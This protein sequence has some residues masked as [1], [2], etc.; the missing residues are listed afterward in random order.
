MDTKS[1]RKSYTAEF[2]RQAVAM[3]VAENLPVAE[4]ARRL[5]VNPEVLRKWKLKHAP[6]APAAERPDPSLADEVRRLRE[7]VRQL[8]MEREILKKAATFF[9]K[10]AT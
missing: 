2:R 8:T 7:Q 10:E 6:P 5:G 4:V 9:A 3:V 1:T